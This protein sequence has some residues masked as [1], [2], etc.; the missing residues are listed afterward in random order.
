MSVT[1]PH[2][3]TLLFIHRICHISCHIQINVNDLNSNSSNLNGKWQLTF[4]LCRNC[5]II[6]I[7]ICYLNLHIECINNITWSAGPRYDGVWQVDCCIIFSSVKI[8]LFST[9]YIQLFSPVIYSSML[10]FLNS[11]I[12]SSKF[13]YSFS[14]NSTIN[15]HVAIIQLFISL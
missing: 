11:A 3:P 10:L 8:Q 4:G 1:S 5:I 2:A 14:Y 7:N 15:L 9:L 13:N 12:P 6:Y